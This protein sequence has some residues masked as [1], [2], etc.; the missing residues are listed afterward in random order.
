L[1]GTDPVIRSP[2]RVGEA[3]GMAQLL[4]GIT[5]AAIWRARTGQKTNVA[6]DIIDALH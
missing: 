3:S 6:I 4:I 2:H 5:G 1:H